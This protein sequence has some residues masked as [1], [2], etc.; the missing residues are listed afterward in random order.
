[1]HLANLNHSLDFP[2]NKHYFI[3]RSHL[4]TSVY[5]YKHFR[6]TFAYTTDN[7]MRSNNKTFCSSMREKMQMAGVG[8]CTGARVGA[9]M[10]TMVMVGGGGG[11]SKRR[12]T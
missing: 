1:M 11:R 4:N 12:P 10:A 9:L 3:S 2:L 5:T 8:G 6:Y 7:H